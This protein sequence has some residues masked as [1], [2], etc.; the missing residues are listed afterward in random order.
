MKK[1]LALVLIFIFV[2]SG[3][4]KN[5]TSKDISKISIDMD[6]EKVE[7]VLGKPSFK[8]TDRDDLTGKY[9]SITTIYNTRIEFDRNEEDN[10]RGYAEYSETYKAINEKKNV[11][12]YV[13]DTETEEEKIYIYFINKKVSFFYSL[14]TNET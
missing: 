5:L 12:L 13:Y 6:Q 7:E 4:G 11:E 3:C 14:N 9:D 2:L 8:T 1:S 10:L